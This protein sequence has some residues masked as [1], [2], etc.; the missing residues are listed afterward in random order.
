METAPPLRVIHHL[1]TEQLPASWNT[2]ASTQKFGTKS[3]FNLDSTVE[4]SRR[5]LEAGAPPGPTSPTLTY[6]LKAHNNPESSAQETKSSPSALLVGALLLWWASHV[7]DADGP[8]ADTFPSTFHRQTKQ[9]DSRCWKRRRPAVHNHH[10]H[11][12]ALKHVR[13]LCAPT[14]GLVFLLADWKQ[15]PV[16]GKDPDPGG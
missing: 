15:A 7:L 12:R 3:G 8:Q 14:V 6:Q 9:G 13:A 5:V 10:A 4:G 16:P 11:S 1:F 2:A